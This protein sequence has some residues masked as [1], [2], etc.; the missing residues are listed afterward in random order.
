MVAIVDTAPQL[1]RDSAGALR[2][3]ILSALVLAPAALAAAWLGGTFLLILTAAAGGLMGWEWARLCGHGRVDA[4]GIAIIAAIIAGTIAVAVD[5]PRLALIILSGGALLAGAL[6]RRTGALA[7]AVIGVVW[8]GLPCM[9]LIWLAK[10]AAAGRTT[11]FLILAVVWAT[12]IGA[13]VTGRTIGGPRLA[14]RISPSKTWSGL[15]GGVLCATIAGTGTA[16]AFGT[17]IRPSLPL[18]CGLLA[19]IAQL[20]DLAESFAKRRFGVKDSSGL[21]PGHG[22]LLDRLD[23]L[24]TV[25]PAVAFLDLVGG[26]SVVA[27]R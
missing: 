21:I 2:L 3:R 11:V 24:L 19:V 4:R 5:A 1:A 10:D 27:G 25:I 9:A 16:I 23:G 13:Y 22:G 15:L 18:I 20:G 14:P 12:D 6:G 7:T 8:I 26:G 17:P